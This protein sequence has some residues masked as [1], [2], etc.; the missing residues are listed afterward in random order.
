MEEYRNVYGDDQQQAFSPVSELLGNQYQSQQSL[1]YYPQPQQPGYLLG[2]NA[3]GNIDTGNNNN[4]YNAF[5]SS[6]Y[7]I[8]L[9]IVFILGLLIGI[10]CCLFMGGGGIFFYFMGKK[11]NQNGQTNR[12]KSIPESE[13]VS[14]VYY[15]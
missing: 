9:P 4:G 8:L 5:D 12:Y 3:Y 10:C 15:I 14:F 2:Y 1:Y 6:S 13:L 7:A 11:S